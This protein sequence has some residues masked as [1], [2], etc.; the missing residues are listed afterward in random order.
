ME[1]APEYHQKEVGIESSSR[2]SMEIFHT[3]SYI[4]YVYL[5]LSALVSLSSINCE[6]KTKHRTDQQTAPIN[7]SAGLDNEDL[8]ILI[9]YFDSHIKLLKEKKSM[10]KEC[11]DIMVNNKNL[12]YQYIEA[13]K[14]NDN[15]KADALWKKLDSSTIKCNNYT[16]RIE[17]ID[18]ELD[19]ISKGAIVSGL[20][21]LMGSNFS[22]ANSQGSRISEALMKQQELD[23]LLQDIYLIYSDTR[24]VLESIQKQDEKIY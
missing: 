5:L 7:K 14:N 23:T 3:S 6:K 19:Q 17:E 22:Y 18:Q 10:L 21:G 9:H 15:A 16:I 12:N 8:K 13:Q 24:K 1:K 2:L 20:A 4:K 11:L